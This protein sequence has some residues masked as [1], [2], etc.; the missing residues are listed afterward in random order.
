MK[1]FFIYILLR[2]GVLQFLCVCVCVCV[3]VKGFFNFNVVFP[4]P[5]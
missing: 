1:I 4:P 5:C 2:E 3:C